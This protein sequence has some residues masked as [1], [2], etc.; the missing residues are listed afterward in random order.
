[1][2]GAEA[3]GDVVEIGHGADVDPGLRH[4]DHDIGAAEA[5]AVDQQH[6]LVGIGNAFAHQVFA[7][8]AEMHRAARQ[9]RGDLAR[10][11]IGD[12]DIVE[13]VDGAAIVAGAARLGQRKSGP[14]EEGL[15]VFL[16]A[17]LRRNRENE[18]RRHDALPLEPLRRACGPA[19]SGLRPRPKTRPPG[20][21]CG[22]RA[23]SSARHSVRPRPAA[24]RRCPWHAVRIR[25]RCN[26]RGRGRTRWKSA[27]RRYRCRARP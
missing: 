4:R 12:L 18:R 3:G 21:A 23:G 2:L 9:L 20:S 6:A 13:P 14:R 19:A 16:Q 27:S 25:S 1:M 11:Q 5:E 8:D 7:G 22:R 17:A 24:R 26:S 15:G 10:R